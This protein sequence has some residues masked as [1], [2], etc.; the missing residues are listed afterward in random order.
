VVIGLSCVCLAVYFGLKYAFIPSKLDVDHY[1]RWFSKYKEK[2]PDA[3]EEAGKKQLEETQGP[4][5]LNH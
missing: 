5:L 1:D 3:E 2:H 4:L